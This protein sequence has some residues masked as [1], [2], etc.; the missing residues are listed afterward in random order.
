M[1]GHGGQDFVVGALQHGAAF[2]QGAVLDEFGQ[3]G[4]G[5][6]TASFNPTWDRDDS[7]LTYSLYRDG[8]TKPAAST[9]VSDRYW[10]RSPHTVQDTKAP[11]GEHSYRLVVSDAGGNTISTDP[12]TVT[13]EPGQIG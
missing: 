11:G 2:G 6:V 3:H 4:P 1:A 5:T 10:S 7:T 9:D 8:E 13:V 12:V